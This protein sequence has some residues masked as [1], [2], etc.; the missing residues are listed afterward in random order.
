MI[1]RPHRGR[2]PDA[3]VP[4]G[5]QLERTSDQLRAREATLNAILEPGVQL[6]QL[7]ASGSTNA[8]TTLRAP[9]ATTQPQFGKGRMVSAKITFEM[10][11]TTK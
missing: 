6:F 10:P 2:G 1:D 11:S 3:R 8:M 4:V 7:T 5:Q 9:L